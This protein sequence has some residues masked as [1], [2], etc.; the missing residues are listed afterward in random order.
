MYS[1]TGG[2]SKQISIGESNIFMRVTV[3][4]LLYTLKHTPQPYWLSNP[5]VSGRL[6]EFV[7]F[8]HQLG[9]YIFSV[10]R[11]QAIPVIYLFGDVHVFRIRIYLLNLSGVSSVKYPWK[12]LILIS[13][14][15]VWKLKIKPICNWLNDFYKGNIPR[16]IISI[17]VHLNQKKTEERKVINQFYAQ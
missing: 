1:S 3:T 7:Y 10:N 5:H 9:M 12:V 15:N 13:F 8:W 17:I 11:L 2:K 14:I 6:G 16:Y 4:N